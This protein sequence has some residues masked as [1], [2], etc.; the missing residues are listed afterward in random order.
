MYIVVLKDG[1]SVRCTEGSAIDL[2]WFKRDLWA[3][4]GRAYNE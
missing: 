1:K 4:S 3:C 2:I